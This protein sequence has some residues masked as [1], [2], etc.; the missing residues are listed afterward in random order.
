MCDWLGFISLLTHQ[1]L[2]LAMLADG[3]HRRRTP[4]RGDPAK[5]G[6]RCDSSAGNRKAAPTAVR[7]AADSNG[8]Q[9]CNASLDNTQA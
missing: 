3:E 2:D 7:T 9:Y 1:G 4:P 5:S 6:L 8:P